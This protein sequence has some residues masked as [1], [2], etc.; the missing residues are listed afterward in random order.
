[1][2]VLDAWSLSDDGLAVGHAEKRGL[3]ALRRA[4]GVRQVRA[5]PFLPRDNAV[6]VRLGRILRKVKGKTRRGTART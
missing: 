5:I 1:M 3:I 4:L 6:N 2:D